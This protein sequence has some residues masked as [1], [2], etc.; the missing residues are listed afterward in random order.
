[1]ERKA[2]E[3][4][5]AVAITS[6]GACAATD[7]GGSSAL[8][9]RTGNQAFARYVAASVRSAPVD[10]APYRPAAGARDAHR[11]V[12]RSLTR[13]VLARTAAGTSSVTNSSQAPAVRLADG[14]SIGDDLDA[15]LDSQQ[16]VDLENSFSDV[17]HKPEDPGQRTT[18]EPESKDTEERLRAILTAPMRADGDQRHVGLIAF[19][20]ELSVTEKAHLL[21]QLSDPNHPITVLLSERDDA[22]ISE[23]PR[24][25]GAVPDPGE[26][27]P[28][29]VTAGGLLA[30]APAAAPLP[31]PA[32]APAPF[33]PPPSPPANANVPG[34]AGPGTA[35]ADTGAAAVE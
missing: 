29:V 4:Q 26:K 22:A 23:P 27:K 11:A 2:D 16:S 18:P 19:L 13:A 32:P 25:P 35:A 10:R 8:L 28:A 33:T 20:R 17:E 3:P 31:A 1:V 34:A 21:K 9:L 7:S 24:G 14:S 5:A 12:E 6:P 30:R 15:P